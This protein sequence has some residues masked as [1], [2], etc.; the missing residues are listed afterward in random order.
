[1]EIHR[2]MNTVGRAPAKAPPNPSF[3]RARLDRRD[4]RGSVRQPGSPWLFHV[5]AEVK[6]LLMTR[7]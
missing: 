6:T 7:R 5:H 3:K 2:R 4:A 1:M